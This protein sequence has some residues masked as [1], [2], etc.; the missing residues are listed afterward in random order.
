VLSFMENTKIGVRISLALVMPIAGL[1]IFSGLTVFDKQQIASGMESLQK[2][3]AL[4]PTVSALVHEMQKERGTSAVFI[5]SKGEKFVKELPVQWGVTDEKRTALIKAL[6]AF[7]A[8]AYGAAL[9]GKITV[10]LEAVAG[11]DDTRKAVQGLS[12]EVPKM[13]G[14]YTPTIA[15]LLSIIEEMTVLSTD[16]EVTRAI[17]TYTSFL[18]GKERA[19]LERAMGSGGF[20][21]G[22]FNPVIYRNFVSLIAQQDT[23]LSIFGINGAKEQVEFYKKTMVGPDV[24]DVVRMR[25]IALDNPFSGDTKGVTGPYWFGA[26]TKKIDLLKTVEDKIAADFSRLTSEIQSGA[27][28]TF[29]MLAV[30]T[31]ALLAVTA[32]LVVF[33]VRGITGPL[34]GM[35]D[36][37]SLLAN[38]DKTIEIE[39][40]HRG[41]EIGSMAGAVVVFKNNM[42]KADE[43]GEAQRLDREAKEKRRV[44]MEN[45]IADLESKVT[46]VI[47]S[48]STGSAEIMKI[49]SKM[50]TKIDDS[51][52]RSLEVAEASGRTTSNVETVAAAAEEL[53]AS[54]AEISRQVTQSSEIAS[55]AKKDAE[56]T[57]KMVQG[58]SEAANKIGEVVNLITDIADQTNLLALNATIEAARAGDAGKG[59]AVVASEVKNLANQTAK[60]TEE[61]GSQINAIQSATED[62]AKAIRNFGSTI[63]RISETASA[64]A[65]AVEQ[66]GAATQEIA[67]NIRNVSE[68]AQLVSN[69]V[70]DV[71]RASASSYGSAIRVIW[72]AQ[73]LSGPTQMLREVVDS[74]LKTVRTD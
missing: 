28:S 57:N 48:V 36:A 42:I 22:K 23:Y 43:L 71:S 5:G 6:K 53:S 40:A 24:D 39:G 41:D 44:V 2:L 46:F 51:S 33:I 17:T 70:A 55:T 32:I 64:T 9:T 50:G 73:D 47:D 10:A 65:A 14:Y 16:A 74:F 31:L 29:F 52:N 35:T 15:K 30:I 3:G 8:S 13:A 38:G 67:R 19:G 37:M 34:A 12:I 18:Q 61:I 26:I 11:M 7:N 72:S 45:A 56:Q 68:D 49:A 4:G 54:I 59:F 62:S 1:L 66:Q 58:L 63:A 21:A 69:S 25:E 27:Q 20:S 60:A